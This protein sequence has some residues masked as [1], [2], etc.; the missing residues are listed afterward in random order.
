MLERKKRRNYGCTI[1]LIAMTAFEI[2][3]CGHQKSAEDYSIKEAE[4]ITESAQMKEMIEFAQTEEIIEF[5]Q[6]EETVHET[7]QPQKIKVY[8]ADADFSRISKNQMELT[9]ADLS[10]P[11]IPEGYIV[12]RREALHGK[13]IGAWEDIFNVDMEQ[14]LDDGSFCVTDTLP[15]DAVMQYEYMI[16]PVFSQ[17]CEYEADLGHTFM[18]ANIKLCLDPGHYQGVNEITGEDSYNYAEGDFTLELSL[19]L[20]EI[21]KCEYGID[22]CLTRESGDISIGGY[23]NAELDHSNL[24]L[25]GAYAGEMDCD[26]FISLHTNANNDWAN[27]Y[28]TCSQ[29]L[30][31]N[32]T[33][34]IMSLADTDSEKMVNL[35]NAIGESIT[36]ASFESGLSVT[37]IFEKAQAG[38]IQE[39]TDSFNDGLDI[40]GTVVCR[41]WE[42]RDYY[43][44]LRGAAQYE[45]PGMIIEHGLH[46]VPEI[47][48]MAAEG[49]LSTIWAQADAYGIASGLGFTEVE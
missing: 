24:T 43:A 38:H 40:P 17:E 16:E 46:T 10:E 14:M 20:R 48:R 2:Y 13:G 26:L 9:W 12:H 18:A 35:C 22:A 11:A 41:S 39:W 45:I 47:R 37:D 15:S 42:G 33:V 30:A 36:Q 49:E 19:R 3:G 32:K 5:A 6:M 21:L 8:V 34:I 25:R 1:L 29:P 4:E 31:A 27:G 23:T 28:A 7:E 44:V